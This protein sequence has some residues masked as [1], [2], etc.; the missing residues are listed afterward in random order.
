[1]STLTGQKI[2]NT[3]KQLLQVSTDNSGLS[4][5]VQTVQD[6]AGTNSALQLSNSTVN[7]NG[8]F[9]L[10]GSTLTATAA[11]LNAI[12]D[13][14][15]TTGIVAVSAGQVYGR[16]LTAGT[17]V[18]I[19]NADGTEGNPTIALNPSGVAAG[20]YGPLSNIAVNSVGQ[21]VSISTETSVSVSVINASSF[22]GEYLNLSANASIVGDVNID[23]NTSIGGSAWING[24]VSIVDSL[25]V[26]TNLSVTGNTKTDFLYAVSAEIGD[27]RADTLTFSAVSVS[28]FT[29]NTLTVI[30]S[31]SVGGTFNVGGNVGIGTTSP[32][33][34]LHIVTSAATTHN[35]I[36]Q[37]NS[38]GDAFDSDISAITTNRSWIYGAFDTAAGFSNGG[39]CIQDATAAT[40][41][42]VINSSGNVG[43]GT[44]APTEKLSVVGNVTISGSLVANNLTGV[45]ATFSDNVS[46]ATLNA[47]TN[48]YIAGSPVA[49]ASSLAATSLALATSIDTANTRIT[50][51]SDFAVALSATFATSINNSN[52]NIAAVSVLTSIN[53]AAIT[54][55][56]AINVVGPASSTDNAIARFDSTTGKLLQ[57]S[58]VIITD[59][60]NVGIGTSSPSVKLELNNGGAGSL[61]TF[62]DGVSTNFNF[63]TSGTVGTF[64]TNAGSTSL[65]LK[66]TGA[67]HMRIDSSGNVGIGTSSPSTFGKFAVQTSTNS[68]TPVVAIADNFLSPQLNHYIT[69]SGATVRNLN[70]IAFGTGSSSSANYQGFMTFSTMAS[71]GG[72]I[73]ER[74]RIT[75]SGNVGIGTTSPSVKFEIQNG[76]SG[77]PLQVFG[78]GNP[79]AGLGIS[80]TTTL[81]DAGTRGSDNTQLV[82]RT[83]LAGTETEQFRIDENGLVTLAAGQIKF[84]AT[85]NASS[86]ANTLDDYEE[87][88]WTPTVAGTTTAGSNS[89]SIQFG[90]YT[91]IGRTVR[92]SFDVQL[93]ALDGAMDGIVEVSL[94]FTSNAASG[95]EAGGIGFFSGLAGSVVFASGYVNPSTSKLTLT[96][97]ATGAVSTTQMTHADFTATTRLVGSVEYTV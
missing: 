12:A 31:A 66:T 73:S 14:T 45:S 40:Y 16:T 60:G 69:D 67:E 74:M 47:G 82:I 54:S 22:I 61:V 13:L 9:Q 46:V 4:A 90:K 34:P 91:K 56:T 19:T 62:T 50:S 52:T 10:S 21:V 17:G 36:Y 28:A 79:Y 55:I 81:L 63:S 97:I 88:T 84:P 24:P 78:G 6:G 35:R 49:L 42:L 68:S 95:L 96:K 65:A 64:G 53:A 7:I 51:V 76:G 37:T 33:G 57:N 48:I 80:T 70:Q 77:V 75:A 11:E 30:T 43:I 41:R 39:W 15:G 83:A 86:N 5:T 92:A 32:S 94:P 58:S 38:G 29:A 59:A 2:A 87:G 72:T 44:T 25:Y 8:T 26:E 20:S 85:Q 1:M 23:G 27:L 18:S 3:Y 89:Y 93:S 71:A